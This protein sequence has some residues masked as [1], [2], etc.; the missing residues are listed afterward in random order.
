MPT[1]IGFPKFSR[2]NIFGDVHKYKIGTD[3]IL[4]KGIIKLEYPINNNIVNNWTNLE[5]IWTDIFDNMELNYALITETAYNSFENR[6]KILELLFETF[7]MDHINIQLGTVL[8]L[9]ASGK[10]TGLVIDSGDWTTQTVAVYD[11]YKI[12][13][14]VQRNNLAGRYITNEICKQYNLISSSGKKNKRTNI[15]YIN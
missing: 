15:Q 14:S 13:C 2:Y 6:K 4:N 10:I 8:A 1:V 5:L 3:V 11:G 12:D 9:Y 7:N